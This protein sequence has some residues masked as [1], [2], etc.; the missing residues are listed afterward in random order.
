MGRRGWMAVTAAFA[1]AFALPASARAQRT[2]KIATLAPEG[3]SWMKLF[4][5]WDKAVQKRTHGRLKLKFQPGGVAGDERDMV[6]LMSQGRIQGAALTG[7]GVGLIQPE[8]RVLELPFLVH[9]DAE[10]DYIRRAMDDELRRKV[11][12]RGFVVLCWGDAG[13][14]HVFSGPLVATRADFQK[15]K[16]WAWTDDPIVRALLQAF[17]VRGVPLGVPDVLPGLTTGQIDVVY[18]SPLTTLSLGWYRK[19]RYM[20][21]VPLVYATGALVV[22]K[23][24]VDQL[25]PE[26]RQA[27]LETARAL[28]PKL[29]RTVREGNAAAMVQLRRAGIQV[30]HL[31]PGV[32]AGF[33]TDAFKVWRKLAG[34]V[35]SREA[36]ERVKKLLAGYRAGTR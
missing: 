4:R 3:S 33:Q 32:V 23:R 27:L 25:E 34:A 6:R 30:V 9:S 12:D 11:E 2:L 21:D 26:D 1:L 17:G 35:Y 15:A 24:E 19:V 28:E 7:Q 18:G 31:E 22:A 10:L 13:W 14:I 16:V 36:L 20:I 8:V 29:L 5:E